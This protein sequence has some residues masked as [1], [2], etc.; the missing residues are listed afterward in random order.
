MLKLSAG[1][2]FILLIVLLFS[3]IPVSLFAQEKAWLGVQVQSMSALQADGSSRGRTGR[4]KSI[5]GLLVVFVTIGSPAE[6]MGLKNGDIILT[7]DGDKLNHVADLANLVANSKPEERIS[8]NIM[9]GG[10]KLFL[11]GTLGVMPQTT[12]PA[13][14]R[15]PLTKISDDTEIIVQT[16]NTSGV[17][18][19]IFSPSGKFL[20]SSAVAKTLNLWD[21][22][23]GKEIRSFS[24]TEDNISVFT[25]SR[26]ESFFIT[27][28]WT[29]LLKMRDLETGATI[30]T[31][32]GHSDYVQRALFSADGKIVVTGSSDK[33]V[34]IW[35]AKTGRQILTLAGNVEAVTG[36]AF[37]SDEKNI[38]S[39]SKDGV[40]RLW[41]TATG[42]E[43]RTFTGKPGW[44]KAIAFSPDGKYVMAGN[45]RTNVMVW[46]ISTGREIQSFS[47]KPEEVSRVAFSPDARRVLSVGTDRVFHL[48]DVFS[49][50]EIFSFTGHSILIYDTSFSHDGKYIVSGSE[51]RT[52]KIWDAATGIQLKTLTGNASWIYEAS[53]SPAGMQALSV[54]EDRSIKLWDI[55]TGKQISVFRFRWTIDSKEEKERY[56]YLKSIVKTAIFSRDGNSVISRAEGE[57][58]AIIIWNTAD[59][60]VKNYFIDQ[61]FLLGKNAV[62][63]SPDEKLIISGGGDKLVKIWDVASGKELKRFAGHESEI[64]AVSFSSDGKYALSAGGKV[65][66]DKD[67]TIRVWEVETGKE[68]RKFVGH[69]GA[70]LS[71][72]FSPDGKY[73]AS[74]SSDKTI[75]LW[76]IATGG[77]LKILTGHT[78]SVS[79]VAFSRNGKMILSACGDYLIKLWDVATGK[80]IRT[81]IGH[82]AWVNAASF[83]PDGKKI[84]S[85]SFDATT[86]IWDIATGREMARFIGFKDG[87]WVVITPEGYYNSSPNGHRHLSLRMGNSIFGIDQFYDVFYRPDIVAA[88]LKGED[89]NGL[90]TLTIAEAV[91]NPPP[92]VQFTNAGTPANEPRVKACYQISNTGGGIGEVRV[93]HNGKLVQSDGFYRDTAAKSAQRIKVASLNSRA[94]YAEMRSIKIQE[95]AEQSPVK[96]ST[97][98]DVYRDCREID[99]VSGENEVNITAFNGQNTVQSQLKSFSFHSS[100]PPQEPHLYILSVGIDKYKD[101]NINLKYAKKDAA[102]IRDKLVRQSASLYQP[103]NIHAELIADSNATKINIIGKIDEWARLIKPGDGF[104]LFVAGHGVL[105]HNQYYMLTHDY[106]GAVSDESLVSSNEI[107]EMSKKI[108][109]LHQLLIFDTCHAGG[110]DYI[111]SGLYD[112]RISV[113]A[114]K[115]GLHIYASANDKQAAMDGYKGNGL[116]TYTLLDGLNNNKDADRN[117]DGKITVVGLGEYTKKKTTD[118]SREIGHSQTPLII[119]FGKDTPLYRLK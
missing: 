19:V 73:I 93:F 13:L 94:I 119:N 53:F 116:F 65:W 64:N 112:A 14:E 71:A 110:V 111:V 91:K 34:K 50:R 87:E 103:E 38:L 67:S 78:G 102:D 68:I 55:D 44:T 80:E 51:D 107:V 12:K 104:I 57:K 39:A 5:E 88:K 95:K 6:R 40:L 7:A 24:D 63:F 21:V 100:L 42:G 27:G 76:N 61:K 15:V 115:M 4:V 29:G 118:I 17:S 47:I 60:K 72:A 82:T 11:L 28:G 43:I 105:L 85:A 22:E 26:D 30:W 83:S 113:L 66:G 75:R 59:G 98:G 62:Q 33:T 45:E 2:L 10:K 25:F 74:G 49:A 46:E 36:L 84:I 20:L 101:V 106:D 108:K 58:G 3:L 52:I 90:I 70:I 77:E 9:R 31:V 81:F 48:W 56:E 109:S 99:V 54:S 89:I 23:T 41:D 92:E 32:K 16:G 96:S 79:S 69:T 117:K 18:R 8:L 97:K 35:D 1:K 37:S 114:K 86:R